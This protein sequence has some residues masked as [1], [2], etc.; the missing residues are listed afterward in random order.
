VGVVNEASLTGESHPQLKE[1]IPGKGDASHLI[2]DMVLT[3][4]V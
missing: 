4:I 3:N 1:E 2:Y